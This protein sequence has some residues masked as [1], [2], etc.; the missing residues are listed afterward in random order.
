LPGSLWPAARG[1]WQSVRAIYEPES[2]AYALLGIP[3]TAS[4]DEVDDAYRKA[5][6]TWHPDK[7]SAP[8]AAEMFHTIQKASRMLRNP[9][10]RKLYDLERTRWRRERGLSDQ[11]L[12]KKRRVERNEPL[13]PPPEWLEP[14]IK[15]HFDAVHIALQ[16]PMRRARTSSFLY[17]C[18]FMAAAG[19]LLRG[20]L[21][22]FGLSLVLF[23]IGRVIKTP[24]HEGVLSWAKLA[25][26]RKLAEY[27]LLDQ[28]AA[29]YEKFTIPYSLLKVAI[30]E[31]GYEYQIEIAG[32]PKA[33]IPVLYRTASK[34]EA[35]RYARQASDYFNLPLAA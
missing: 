27:H 28:R 21:R 11:P 7:S 19:A 18:A 31:R 29:R 10:L 30:V 6:L 15:L 24:P 26:A 25:P 13:P 5:A 16:A 32:F 17:G 22:L 23:A 8:D 34:S 9:T 2:D 4:Q 1:L 35:R 12:K 20:D 3:P 14:A 33:S